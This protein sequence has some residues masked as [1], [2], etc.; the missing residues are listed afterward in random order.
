MASKDLKKFSS[1]LSIEFVNPIKLSKVRGGFPKDSSR[2]FSIE[3][4]FLSR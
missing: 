3:R 4:A 2:S 1:E